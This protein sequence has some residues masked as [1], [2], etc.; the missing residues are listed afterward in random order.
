MFSNYD[1]VIMITIAQLENEMK[2][3]KKMPNIGDRVSVGY[4]ISEGSKS[5]TQKFDG[6][7]IAI[8]HGGNRQ[9]FTVRKESL[10]VGVERIFPLYS[11][12]VKEIEIKKKHKVRRA[13]LYYQRN[14]RG[15]AA[16]LREIHGK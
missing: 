10:G 5:R 1:E 7:V 11:P 6:L 14:L 16:R 9:T 15:K 2:Q 12:F 8:K 4:E 3:D 13:K